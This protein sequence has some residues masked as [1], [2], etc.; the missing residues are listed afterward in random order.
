MK[1]TVE[2]T[3]TYN[4]SMTV[5]AESED[6]ALQI[7]QNGLNADTLKE[8]PDYVSI[9]HGN[10]TFGEATADYADECEEF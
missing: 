3:C 5:E 7:A 4:G 8:F 6:E 2:L 9:P 10:F 1:Y